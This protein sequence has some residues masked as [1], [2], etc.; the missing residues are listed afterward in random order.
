MTKLLYGSIPSLKLDWDI[1][2]QRTTVKEDFSRAEFWTMLTSARRSVYLP[3]YVSEDGS[4]L[5]DQLPTNLEVGVWGIKIIWAKNVCDFSSAIEMAKHGKLQVS[6]VSQLLYITDNPSEAD[7][8]PDGKTIHIISTAATYG[9]DGISAYERALIL[10]YATVGGRVLNEDEYIG[11]IHDMNER[12]EQIEFQEGSLEGSTPG[13]GSRW[14][15]YKEEEANRNTAYETAEAARDSRYQQTEERRNEVYEEHEMM[16]GDSFEDFL[17]EKDEDFKNAEAKRES[18]EKERV[19]AEGERKLTFSTFMQNIGTTFNTWLNQ[20]KETFTRTLGNS[21]QEANANGSFWQRF[22]A[23]IG[24][25]TDSFPTYNTIWAIF[26]NLMDRFSETYEEREDDRDIK[27]NRAEGSKDGSTAGDGTRWGEYKKNES[28]RDA[29]YQEKVEEIEETLGEATGVVNEALHT[30]TSKINI[31]LGFFISEGSTIIEDGANHAY[32]PIYLAKGDKLTIISSVADAYISLYQCSDSKFNVGEQLQ[33]VTGVYGDPMLTWTANRDGWFCWKDNCNLPCNIIIKSVDTIYNNNLKWFNKELENIE[34]LIKSGAKVVNIADYSFAGALMPSGADVYAHFDGGINYLAHYVSVLDPEGQ[35]GAL[36]CSIHSDG[37]GF[38]YTHFVLDIETGMYKFAGSYSSVVGDV[39]A[40]ITKAF[41]EDLREKIG[42]VEQE[43][44]QVKESMPKLVNIADYMEDG[45]K[46]GEIMPADADDYVWVQD[47][48]DGRINYIVHKRLVAYGNPHLVFCTVHTRDGKGTWYV[49]F[50]LYADQYGH[51][52]GW[53]YSTSYREDDVP[54]SVREAFN[55]DLRDKIGDLSALQT[56]AQDNL[57]EAINEVASEV[58]EQIKNGA[59]VVDI[60][61]YVGKI[62]EMPWDADVFVAKQDG[63]VDIINHKRIIYH[64]LNTHFVFCCTNHDKDGGMVYYDFRRKMDESG[65]PTG[66]VFSAAYS[67]QNVPDWVKE[68]FN[69]DLRPKLTELGSKMVTAEDPEGEPDEVEELVSILDRKADKEDV[70]LLGSEVGQVKTEVQ[71]IADNQTTIADIERAMQSLPDGQAVSAQVAIN[72]AKVNKVDAVLNGGTITIESVIS[73]STWSQGAVFAD[74]SNANF[75]ATNGGQT[76]YKRSGYVDISSYAAKNAKLEMSF[77]RTSGG[78]YGLVFYTG[79]GDAL[80]ITDGAKVFVDG[81]NGVTKIVAAIPATAKYFRTTYWADELGYESFNCVVKYAGEEIE[82][83]T[84]KMAALDGDVINVK[85]SV[86]ALERTSSDIEKELNGEYVEKLIA[87]PFDGWKTGAVIADESSSSFG[88]VNSGR[89]DYKYSGYAD[90]EAYVGKTLR[91]SFVR[92]NAYKNLGLVFY[93]GIGDAEKIYTGTSYVFEAGTDGVIVKD[94]QIPVGAKYVRTTYW[95]DSKGYEVFSA[96]A[97]TSGR[98]SGIKD[99]VAKLNESI[100]MPNVVDYWGD[101][102][103]AGNQDGT[104]VTRASVLKGLLGDNW[105]V[106]NYGS[107]GELSNAIC[108][109]EGG[110]SIVLKEGV[111]I[112][113]NGSLVDISSLVTDDFGNAITFTSSSYTNPPTDAG[114]TLN[115]CYVNGVKCRLY[116]DGV[117]SHP[118]HI[119]IDDTSVKNDI[120]TTRPTPILLNENNERNGHVMI[121]LMGQNDGSFSDQPPYEDYK[122]VLI[123][124][125]KY[126]LEHGKTSRYLVI[127]LTCAIDSSRYRGYYN[128]QADV[129]KALKQEFGRHFIDFVNYATTKIYNGGNVVNSYGM[130]DMGLTPTS[131]ELQDIVLGNYQHDS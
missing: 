101:S 4:I 114:Q 63:I 2:K 5:C 121:I 73:V 16:R 100:G 23:V 92:S 118:L 27:Y 28:I 91:V 127:S 47:T 102:L 80:C 33:P 68:A 111:T 25:Q 19:K 74:T 86:N 93:K 87:I 3:T 82:G 90:I 56:T 94:V 125:I 65:R 36:F 99:D 83:L 107:G 113:S 117:S 110:M 21:E 51:T 17:N 88:G 60:M 77:V 123:N 46:Y 76:S 96:Y 103:T 43:V 30:L 14:G 64:D 54:E 79:T 75:G 55:E 1:Y 34:D 12:M 98:T 44:G 41:N 26:N 49:A 130:D 37:K 106:N 57:V 78:K 120:V 85:Q 70:E 67:Y 22:Y 6:E 32:G 48:D 15:Q 115:P 81:E 59:K 119:R 38:I 40:W 8:V 104:G 58:E 52:H 66:L 31:N 69:E 29:K 39:P 108:A 7:N 24:K 116:K 18:A 84:D 89:T 45:S 10:G 128:W 13:D 95:A 9:Y 105:V 50:T 97:V 131:E 20:A 124:R 109:R 53:K 42:D 61:K 62:I 112:P 71:S 11:N 72:T 35:L 129:N 122:N 126:M